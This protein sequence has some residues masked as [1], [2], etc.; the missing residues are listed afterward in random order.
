MVGILTSA[1]TFLVGRHKRP[2]LLLSTTG[3]A[4]EWVVKRALPP[5]LASCK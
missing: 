1:Y 4:C 3:P 2:W 5:P